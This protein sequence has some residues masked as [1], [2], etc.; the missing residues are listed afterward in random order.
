MNPVLVHPAETPPTGPSPHG[1]LLTFSPAMRV[2]AAQFN[3]AAESRDGVLVTGEP[4]SGRSF[5]AR[6]LAARA[7]P[8]A[9]VVVLDCAKEP[10]QCM[11]QEL[12]GCLSRPDGAG[13]ERRAL[14]RVVAPSL[15]ARVATGGTLV[16][17]HLAD[18]PARVQRR[19][20]RLLRDGEAVWE[21]G[22]RVD[23]D[24]RAIAT[25]DASFDTAVEEGRIR[26]DL[27]RQVSVIRLEVPPLRNR[28]ED[29]PAMAQY[30]LE[31]ACR[32][33]GQQ[34]RVLTDPAV[35]LL[36]ALPWRGNAGELA[37]LLKALVLLDPGPAVRLEDV[38]RH[39][40]L[41]ASAAVPAQAGTLRQARAHFERDYILAVLEQHHGRIGDAAK[42][43]GIQR[44]NL[45]RKMRSLHIV[46]RPPGVRAAAS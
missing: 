2:L 40:R 23:L 31:E 42:V 29:I 45:Y 46:H 39:L 9:P 38:L 36:T 24:V 19:L 35:T 16:L 13:E 7:R 37:A 43:L 30:F 4:G 41:D 12:F 10:A 3:R 1:D 27:A 5:I 28:R 15:I 21:D 18:I 33:A 14:E 32:A 22:R 26:P 25:A 8:S 20:A 34:S 44:T 17:S 11:E 6:A